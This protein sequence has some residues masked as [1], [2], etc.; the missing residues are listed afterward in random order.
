M[1]SVGFGPEALERYRAL[2]ARAA[3]QGN[4]SAVPCNVAPTP[5]SACQA[6]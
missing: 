1:S 4:H 5:G 6:T 2:L 3:I